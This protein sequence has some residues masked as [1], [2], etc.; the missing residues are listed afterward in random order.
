MKNQKK[1]CVIH[2]K[3]QKY[4]SKIKDMTEGN[5][6]RITDAKEVG[7]KQGGESK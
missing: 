4:Y 6:K 5:E 7:M 2:Y 3:G 1:K